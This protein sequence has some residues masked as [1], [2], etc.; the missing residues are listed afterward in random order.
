MKKSSCM[1]QVFTE[2]KVLASCARVARSVS[3]YENGVFSEFFVVLSARGLLRAAG[4]EY[5]TRAA[6]E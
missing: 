5:P 3:C 4:Q 2:P 1:Q 6:G